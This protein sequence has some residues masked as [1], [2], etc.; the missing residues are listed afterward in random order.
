M[1]T[2]PA[3]T[4]EL[5]G[6]HPVLDF[7]NTVGGKRLV[8]PREHLRNVSDLLAWSSLSGVVTPAEA[9]ALGR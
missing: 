3:V 8:K 6:G 1:K 4:F 9:K 5:T 2:P 7:V